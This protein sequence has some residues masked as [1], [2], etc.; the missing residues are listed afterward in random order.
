MQSAPHTLRQAERAAILSPALLPL[1]D[2]SI[3]SWD[4]KSGAC[5]ISCMLAYAY[6]PAGSVP[7]ISCYINDKPQKAF[8]LRSSKTGKV[9]VF[10][11]N[12]EYDPEEGLVLWN[13]TAPFEPELGLA[14]TIFND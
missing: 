3:F 7:W 14:L 1:H 13:C 2:A 11:I 12:P 10:V 4:G 6:L 8:R 9:V 5:D